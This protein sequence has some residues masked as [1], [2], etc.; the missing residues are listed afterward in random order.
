[1]A[2][3]EALEVYPD[4]FGADEAITNYA[5]GR[6]D[7]VATLIVAEENLEAAWDK[8][9]RIIADIKREFDLS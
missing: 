6:D 1:M 3:T 5:A 7:W 2:G 4:F 8:R 9:N